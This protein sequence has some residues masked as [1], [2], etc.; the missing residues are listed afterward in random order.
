[1]ALGGLAR[2]GKSTY[3]SV[4]REVFRE[5]GRSAI[6]VPMDAWLLSQ[7]ERTSG[8]VLGRFDVDGLERLVATLSGRKAAVEVQLRHYDRRT[9]NSTES[10]LKLHIEPDDIVIFEGVPALLIERL[11]AAAGLKIHV[12][13]SDEERR[14]RFAAEYR[15][16]AL[17]ESEADALYREREL[18]EHPFIEASAKLADRRFGS[19]R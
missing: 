2:S 8:H 14:A 17:S 3:A 4:L 5:R 18:D 6:V 13:C 15:A 11:V 16:R 19:A 1:V 12:E 9:R 10:D 7:S